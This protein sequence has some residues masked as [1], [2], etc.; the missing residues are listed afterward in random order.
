MSATTSL[1]PGFTLDEPGAPLPPGFRLDATP[2]VPAMAPTH[3]VSGPTGDLSIDL[4]R[5]VGTAAATAMGG[6]LSL[7]N[8]TAQGVDWLGR[9]VG[10][11][12]G[13]VAA[14]NSIRDPSDPSKPLL[15]D[16]Q[17]ARDMAFK[18]MGG[19]EYQPETWLGRRGQDALTGGVMALTNPR[20]IP[21]M[22]G[23][24][25]SGGAA[26]EAFPTHPLVAALLGSYP[27]ARAGN[28]AVTLPQR[29]V[30]SAFGIGPTS[31]P[32]GAFTRQGLPT[33]LAGTTTGNPTLAY[34]E[35]F[36]A[37]MPGSEGAVGS[38]RSD[39]LSSWQDRLHEVANGLGSATTPTQAGTALQGAAR[40]W[41][42][43]FKTNTGTLWNNFRAIVPPQTQIPVSN[44]RTTLDSV[45]QDF[46][47]ADNL[48]K[49]LQ[50]GMASKLKEALSAD[51]G[52]GNSLPWQAVQATR[53]RLG[54]MLENAQPVEDM[55]HSA[56]KRLYGSLSGDMQA[57]AAAVSPD[58]SRAFNAANAATAAGHDLLENHLNPILKATNPEDA[59]RFA[60]AQ[61][62][63]GGSRLGA[64]TFNLPGAAGELG[65]YALRNA[66]TNTGSPSALA[67]AL[68]G[69]RPIYSA[70]AQKV[71]FPQPATQSD[72]ADLATAGR[73]MQPLEKDIANSPT[74][75]HAA[76]GL[77]RVMAAAEMARSGHELAGVP[78]A[79][80]G[81]VLGLGAPEILGKAA[82]VTALNPYLS[83]LY[84]RE[85]PYTP[86]TPS[87]LARTILAPAVNAGEKP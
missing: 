12:P 37:R 24:G 1:P 2:A 26:A 15:P 78:G 69:R 38:A 77:G 22:M 55:A 7:P 18:T 61:A 50:P 3:P 21:S 75:T 20:S 30:T 66:A 34:A 57:G 44:F 29:A 25:A 70:D 47:G 8:T 6:L 64:I 74:A 82:Q 81:G 83:A 11:D 45:L 5:R 56:I 39:L 73:S 35:K 27:G 48:A 46:G 23:A 41:L 87:L 51:L 33:S 17:S 49:A 86:P 36:A 31:Q 71:L 65:S 80:A 76:R 53:S 13:N 9:Q 68:T 79:I 10:F 84:G 58:A 60:M 42:D 52:T 4:P 16:F 40:T 85:I 59:T 19:T 63:S 62:Q 28:M 67:N 14:F 54:E 43:G 32:Y 72:I